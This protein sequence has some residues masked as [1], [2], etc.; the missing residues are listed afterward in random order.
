MECLGFWVH[1][2]GGALG[3]GVLL[4][5]AYTYMDQSGRALDGSGRFEVVAMLDMTV[6]P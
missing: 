2:M 6:R 3:K 4:G 1:L 5:Q